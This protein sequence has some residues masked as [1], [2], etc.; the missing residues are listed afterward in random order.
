VTWTRTMKPLGV[1]LVIGAL[2]LLVTVAA[3]AGA[4][5]KPRCFGK[6]ATI[7]R[8]DTG[9]E[10][11]GTEGNDVIVA[12]GGSDSVY[13]LGG[14][15]RICGGF[16]SD[17]LQGD[18]GTDRVSGE[19]G[20][21]SFVNGGGGNDRVFGGPGNDGMVWGDQGNDTVVG[22]GGGD[23]MDG[24]EG[25]DL[26][27]GGPGADQMIGDDGNDVMRGDAG[28]DTL[29]GDDGDDLVVGG[30]GDDPFILGN[31][32]EDTLRGSAGRDELR[33][34]DGEADRLN[35]GRGRDRCDIDPV[36][37]L[38]EPISL[39]THRSC[40]KLFE[41]NAAPRAPGRARPRPKTFNTR[42][43]ITGFEFKFDRFRVKVGAAHK[44]CKPQRLV[45]LWRQVPGTDIR[46]GKGRTDAGGFTDVDAFPASLARYYATVK[47]TKLGRNGRRVCEGARSPTFLLTDNP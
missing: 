2:G 26:L 1:A 15:D 14:N 37:P 9:Q 23:F 35:G 19:G 8:G 39:D 45:R 20:D 47:R 3:P 6:K 33:A 22:G 31:P 43:K 13:G 7:V 34:E 16:G 29:G 36:I 11:A 32:G 4:A 30:K 5:A 25:A 24:L 18:E 10:I 27:A 42:A 46:I 28:R 41:A 17:D 44:P 12:G 21:D 40:E 38:P